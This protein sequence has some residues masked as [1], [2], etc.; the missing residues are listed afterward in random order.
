MCVYL[1]CSSATDIDVVAMQYTRKSVE[2]TSSLL[3]SSIHTNDNAGS[4][5]VFVYIRIPRQLFL[6]GFDFNI[7]KTVPPTRRINEIHQRKYTV[8][9]QFFMP[10]TRCNHFN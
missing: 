5:H 8:S 7:T 2:V 1:E 4:F 6:C 10:L 3:V 9:T